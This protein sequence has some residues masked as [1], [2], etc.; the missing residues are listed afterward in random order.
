MVSFQEGASREF[1]FQ[2][3]DPIDAMVEDFQKLAAIVGS[4][5]VTLFIDF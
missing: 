5:H 1:S 4:G 3:Q 2:S